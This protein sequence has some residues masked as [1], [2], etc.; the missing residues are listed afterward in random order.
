[1]RKQRAGVRIVT[2]V[3]LLA[4]SFAANG[5]AVG[6][7]LRYR[8]E[9]F[10]EV[11]D[12]GFTVTSKPCIGLYW[13]SLD[14]FPF[15]YSKID[16]WF[17]G[18]GGGRFGITRHYNRCAGFGRTREVIGWGEFDPEDESTMHVQYSGI[19]GWIL[20]PHGGGPAYTPACVHFFPHLG[21]VGLVWNV[22]WAEL[23][24]FM[25]GWTTIDFAGDDGYERGKWSWPR[26]TEP[27]EEEPAGALSE[28]L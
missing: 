28:E 12:L 20:P 22:R 16:G 14:I 5:C 3:A 25:L 10:A 23:A 1:V 8:A 18:W 19:L 15:G 13:N 17:V 24:D 2:L 4:L 26:R 6:Q 11:A 21:Y 27:T 9:D 7:Y